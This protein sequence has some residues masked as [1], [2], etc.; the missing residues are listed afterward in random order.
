VIEEGTL[1]VLIT[2]CVVVIFQ[3]VSLIE[4]RISGVGYE[5]VLTVQPSVAA[6]FSASVVLLARVVGA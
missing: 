6:N 3:A 4:T 1:A 2:E 5:P